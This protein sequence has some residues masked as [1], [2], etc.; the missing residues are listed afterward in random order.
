MEIYIDRGVLGVRFFTYIVNNKCRMERGN[1]E[2][3]L[4]MVLLMLKPRG[5]IN[6]LIL[7]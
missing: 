6:P 7:E 2:E 5:M 3:D 1:T 4:R